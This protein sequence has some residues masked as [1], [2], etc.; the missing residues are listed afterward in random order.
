MQDRYSAIGVLQDKDDCKRIDVFRAAE[1]CFGTEV[2]VAAD[3][4]CP[5]DGTSHQ[6]TVPL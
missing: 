6:C 2:G 4:K 5:S 1:C 3:L